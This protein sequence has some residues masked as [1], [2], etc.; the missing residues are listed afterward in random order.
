MTTRFVYATRTNS[1]DFIIKNGITY[2]F[3]FDFLGSPILVIDT[4]TGII[5]QQIEYDSWGEILSDTNP[6]FQP[7]GFAGGLYDVDTKLVRF[8]SRDYD[9]EIG[10]WTAMDPVRFLGDDTNLYGYVFNDPVN[11]FD[12]DGLKVD[13]GGYVLKNPIVKE[14]LQRL[15]DAIVA[16]GK[17]DDSFIIRVTGGDRFIFECSEQGPLVFS[18][19][20]NK[21]IPKSDPNKSPHLVER[22]ARAVDLAYEG[23]TDDLF[24]KVLKGKTKFQSA[25]TLRN[26]EDG[27]THIS[28]PNLKKYYYKPKNEKK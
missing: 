1:P 13:W 21:M 22:G 24:D 26:Y 28:L 23:I 20:F 8:G 5:A 15:N 9:P 18:A 11:L 27:H 16:I 25:G 12:S 14:E 19:T 17:P 7:F 6:G 4:A 3:I 2:R 10:R